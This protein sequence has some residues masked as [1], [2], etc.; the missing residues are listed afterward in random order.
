MTAMRADHGTDANLI[1]SVESCKGGVGKTTAALCLA[2][3]LLGRGYKVLFLDMDVTGTNAAAIAKS[4]F[5]SADVHLAENTQDTDNGDLGVN[6]VRLFDRTFMAGKALPDFCMGDAKTAGITLDFAKVNMMGSQLLETGLET[7]GACIDRPAI[8][9]DDLHTLWLLE[10]VK[11]MVS[12]FVVTA[13]KDGAS[14]TAV[15]VD[16]SPGYVGIAPAL[17]EWLTDIG[18]DVGKFLV[19]TS[20][21]VQDLLACDQTIAALHGIYATKW[22]ASRAFCDACVEGKEFTVTKQQEAFFARLAIGATRAPSRDD[23]LA[24]YRCGNAASLEQRDLSGDRYA[25]NPGQYISAVLNRVP[26]AVKTGGLAFDTP[27][28]DGVFYNL[29]SRIFGNRADA[30]SWRAWMVTYDEYIENQFLLQ[31]LQRGRR[32]S[33]RRAHRLL[34]A[35]KLAKEELRMGIRGE[36]VAVGE[37]FAAGSAGVRRLRD[38]LGKTDQIANR[39]RSAVADAGLGHLARL[40]HDEWLPGSI[41]PAFRSALSQLLRD[42]DM[43]FLEMMPFEFDTESLGP[44]ES[45]SMERIK[46]RILTESRHILFPEMTKNDEKLPDMLASVLSCLVGLTLPPPLWY[47]PLEMELPDVL[48][49][50]LVLELKQWTERR[51]RNRPNSSLQAF[52]AQAYLSEAAMRQA[53]DKLE[54]FRFFRH[55]MWREGGGFTEFYRACTYAQA[56]LIDFVADTRFLL[57]LIAAV[58]GEETEKGALFPFVRGIAEEVIVNKSLS[59]EDAPS[60][61]SRALR[62]TQYFMEFDS[63]LDRV[64]VRWGVGNVHS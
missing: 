32:R 39:A 22:H 20:F 25:G 16:N 35:L 49:G 18:P 61:M 38:L 59:H 63:V 58:V 6:L 56:R 60:R 23:P 44:E 41:L 33:E 34:E 19:V 10:F 9:F 12:R 31:L 11:Q 26:R 62:T 27:F 8:L 42:I 28:S 51:E 36:G 45:H 30:R 1:I 50:V 55:S 21:D 43:P 53:R 24:F 13:R 37:L 17:H 4:P 5:W 3:I 54:H 14:A 47:S 29:L 48:A 57:E 52:L 15:I 40:I 7:K 46:K 64:L 2:R